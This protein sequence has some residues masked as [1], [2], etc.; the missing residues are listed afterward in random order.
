VLVLAGCTPALDWREVRPQGADVRV[1][2][3]C[4]PAS[5]ARPVR[6]AGDQSLMSMYSCAA[7]GT[8]YALSFA[9]VKDLAR[10]DAAIDELAIAVQAHFQPIESAASQPAAVRGMTPHPAAATWRLAGRMPDGRTMQERT[11]LFRHGTRVYQL[12]MLGASLDV[13]AQET[14]FDAIQVGP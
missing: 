10:V 2:F 7:E 8:V 13:Q 6:L 1:L 5:H 11:A 3:P 4:R 12:T 14:F 9:D